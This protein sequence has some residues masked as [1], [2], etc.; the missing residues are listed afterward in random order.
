MKFFVRNIVRALIAS[1][2]L[3]AIALGMTVGMGWVSRMMVR[4]PIE[5]ARNQILDLAFQVR[6]HNTAF[7]KVK[8]EDVVIIDIDDASIRELG[9][10]QMWPRGYDAM[11]IDFLAQGH[12][13]AIGIDYL[14]PESDELPSAYEQMLAQRGFSNP[15][16]II[17]ALRTDDML[18]ISI[19]DAGNVYL[20][21]FD[22]DFATDFK[23]SLSFPALRLIPS[24]VKFEEAQQLKHPVLPIPAFANYAKGIGCIS[25]PSMN[26]G[27]VR[28]YHLLNRWP[29]SQIQYV[30]NFTLHMVKDALDPEQ[31]ST[32]QCASRELTLGDSL[33]IPVDQHGSFRLNWLGLQDSIRYISYYKILDGR[34]PLE[35]FENKF[36]FLGTSASGMQDL[37][38]IPSRSIKVPGVEVHAVAFLNMMNGA[39]LKEYNESNAMG[40]LYLQAVLL[41]LFFLLIKPLIGFVASLGLVFGQML[42]FVMYIFPTYHI[43]LPVVSM[44]L[45]TLFAYLGATLFI[46]FI[47]ERKSRRLKMAFSSYVSPDV[48]NQIAKDSSLMKMQGQKQNL[49]VLFSDIRGFTS[50]S[51][52]LEPEEV[53]RVLNQYLSQ[54]S[55]QIFKH[56]GT[57]DKFMGDGIMAIFGAPIVQLDHADRACFAALSMRESLVLFNRDVLQDHNEV[58]E[59]GMGINTGA[60]TVGNIGS[61]RKF[62]YTVIGD[63]VNLG[64]RLEGLTKYF[65]VDI[66]V[67][68]ST[69]NA[70]HPNVFLFREMLPVQVK[71]KEKPVLT[72]T[73]LGAT[74]GA[75]TS[76]EWLQHWELA[77]QDY[78]AHDYVHCMQS[79]SK[80]DALKRRDKACEILN[81]WCLIAREEDRHTDVWIA[82]GK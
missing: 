33:T 15:E 61:K 29:G 55:E 68:E 22:D 6:D 43:I 36:V 75:P 53:V 67:S 54:M 71:G 60:M 44:M 41:V 23:D 59:I 65:G 12:P 78:K 35:F 40:W 21:I 64:S 52:S 49:T 46:Y 32:F 72:Y 24:E 38:T 39:F 70:V 31:K 25:M 37:K 79:L 16:G 9:R 51:E 48:V 57:I 5:G 76:H 66:L 45:I 28:Y 26:D 19:E 47:R 11:V 4:S 82:E 8:P 42:A 69:K 1:L 17:E 80:L 20:S 7:Q 13:K 10:P 63:S 34:V 56:K 3:G 62:D 30:P 50:Y 14:Y 58:F 2:V 73:L 77:L 27:S 81:Q 74:H 18:S